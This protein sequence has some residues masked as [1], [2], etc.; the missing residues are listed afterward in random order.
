MAKMQ[1]SARPA[2]GT[3]VAFLALAR[4]GHASA[5]DI[6]P[7]MQSFLSANSISVV[8][9]SKST[10][11]GTAHGAL[12]TEPSQA[13]PLF[14]SVKNRCPAN[15][16]DAGLDPGNWTVY[17][18]LD[19]LAQCNETM[20]LDF[21]VFNALNDS[22]SHITIRS[23]SAD[24]ES[25]QPKNKVRRAD[26]CSS[27]P[28][29]QKITNSSQLAFFGPPGSS[30]STEDV[31]KLLS[32][33]RLTLKKKM[34]RAMKLSRFLTPG[35]LLLPCTLALKCKDRVYHQ[36]FSTSS[37]TTYRVKGLMTQ[38]WH[39]SVLEVDSASNIP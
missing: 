28:H 30:K 9:T 15:C 14:D 38:S 13:T 11:T 37:S 35:R 16:N 7:S 8:Y 32:K 12:A 1:L 22:E 21:A 24:F 10:P 27:L 19:R 36:C 39:S 25:S 34:L 6:P 2:I 33:F 5:A 3:I 20:L 31:I 18:N 23:C 17:H 4:L 29:S 26:T